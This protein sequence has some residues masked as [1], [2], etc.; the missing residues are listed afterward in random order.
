M[1]PHERVDLANACDNQDIA[2]ALRLSISLDKA[3]MNEFE[4]LLGPHSALHTL[5]KVVAATLF[6]ERAHLFQDA[7]FLANTNEHVP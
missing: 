1:G 4:V 6:L 2:P 5:Q 3:V 7:T